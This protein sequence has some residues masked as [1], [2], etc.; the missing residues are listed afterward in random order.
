MSHDA[1]ERRFDQ[2]QR[3]AQPASQQGLLVTAPS[4][5]PPPTPP[6]STVLLQGDPAGVLLVPQADNCSQQGDLASPS[7]SVPVPL[8]QPPVP[9]PAPEATFTL[10]AAGL[11]TAEGPQP[12][13]CDLQAM[14]SATVS[15]MLVAGLPHGARLQGVQHQGVPTH[16]VP[17]ASYSEATHPLAPPQ[18]EADLADYSLQESVHSDD[19]QFDEDENRDMEFSEDE[20]AL[21]EKPTSTGLFR[22]SLFKALLHK[23]IATTQLAASQLSTDQ[24]GDTPP[25]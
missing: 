14:I 1:L 8:T 13:Y 17:L 9:R 24:H 3:R 12:F 5:P 10:T 18:G 23:A 7:G 19:S 4:Q 25:P 22:P 6:Q 2:A 16:S 15:R 20:D 21:P 11:R